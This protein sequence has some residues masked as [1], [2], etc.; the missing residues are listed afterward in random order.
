MSQRSTQHLYNYIKNGDGHILYNIT[1]E[2]RENL[3]G[4]GEN[5]E[6]KVQ[7]MRLVA[8]LGGSHLKER[9]K[10]EVSLQCENADLSVSITQGLVPT[11]FLEINI[12]PT[13]SEENERMAKPVLDKIHKQALLLLVDFRRKLIEDAMRGKPGIKF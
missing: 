1:R 13:L 8:E 9:L 12:T 11:Y 5:R 4:Q 6:Y 2:W 7:Y 3:G 10:K